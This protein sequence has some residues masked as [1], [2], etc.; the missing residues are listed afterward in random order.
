MK[1]TISYNIQI[2]CGLREHYTNK[3]YSIK[4]VEKLCQNYVNNIGLCVTLTPTKFIYKN[5]NENGVIIGL[6]SYPRF[7]SKQ[8]DILNKAIELSK[9][10]IK[11]L[12]QHR[13]TITTPKESI[14]LES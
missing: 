3:F 9:V 10:L 12:K 13:I 4:K 5:G 2:W 1:K 14:M 6:I 7:P 11:E 8:K